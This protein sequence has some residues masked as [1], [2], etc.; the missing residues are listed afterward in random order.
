MKKEIVAKIK[1]IIS[2]PARDEE[3]KFFM[4]RH[5]MND[6][7]IMEESV[8]Q[9]VGMADIFQQHRS[10]LLCQE[11]PEGL[12]DTGFIN[13]DRITGGFATGEYIIIGGRPGMGKTTLMVNLARQMA[14]EHP[15]LYFTYEM[16]SL[17]LT[18]RFLSAMSEVPLDHILQGR[19]NEDER[20]K[21][22]AAGES[23]QHLHLSVNE[24]GNLSVRAL[25]LHCERMVKERGVRIVMIDY[26]QLMGAYRF[27]NHR[28]IEIGYLSRELKTMAQDLDVCVIVSS[29]LSRAVE[30]RGGGHRPV[31]SDLRDSGSIEQDADK[32][33]FLY[34]PEYYMIEEWEDGESTQGDMELIIAKNRNGVCGVTMLTHNMSCCSLKDKAEASPNFLFVK[35][36]LDELGEDIT[37]D[38]F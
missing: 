21:V 25:R 4:I 32:V 28:D 7:D 3:E 27:R 33:I 15:L 20:S 16:N 9:S 8:Q 29:Q 24:S 31:L 11:L 35:N 26:L 23:L 13:L 34:R 18:S 14:R 5:L 30:T 6:A 17:M 12:M 38:P 2:Y 22:A 10:S 37:T 1:E 19:L 36:R